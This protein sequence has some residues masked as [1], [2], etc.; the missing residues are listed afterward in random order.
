MQ[1]AFLNAL[2]K[3]GT[4]ILRTF[5]WHSNSSPTRILRCAGS[6]VCDPGHRMTEFCGAEKPFT[7]AAPLMGTVH[8]M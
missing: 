1:A 6:R 8:S 3:A 7:T 2:V 4:A 5:I